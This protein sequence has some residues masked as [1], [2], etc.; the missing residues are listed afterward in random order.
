V[1]ARFQRAE[2]EKSPK[3][4]TLKTCRHAFPNSL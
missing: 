4:G 1:A 3:I 2:G